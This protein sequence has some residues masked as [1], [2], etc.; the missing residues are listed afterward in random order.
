[1]RT[2]STSLRAGLASVPKDAD[3]VVVL[4]ADMPGVTAAMIDRLIAG[5]A[6]GAI[7]VPVS[8]GQRGNPVLWSRAHF[9]ALRA[10]TGDTGGRAIIDGHPEAV[11]TVDLGPAAGLDVDTPEAL[12]AVSGARG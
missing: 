4:L 2:V 9:A 10:V 7:V 6:P 5:F 1:M 12:A 11:V 8:G 3:G